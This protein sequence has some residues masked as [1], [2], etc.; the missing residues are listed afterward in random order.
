MADEE[1]HPRLRAALDTIKAHLGA[2]ADDSAA[3]CWAIESHAMALAEQMVVIPRDQLAGAMLGYAIHVASVATGER[4]EIVD[5]GGGELAIERT[6][7]PMET[8]ALHAPAVPA[9]VQ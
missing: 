3:A 2:D 4:L 7:E 8:T 6:G 9:T 5:L 1:V